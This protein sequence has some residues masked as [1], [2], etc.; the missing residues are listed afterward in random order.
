MIK[1]FQ[2]VIPLMLFGFLFSTPPVH[3]H[4]KVRIT[5]GNNYR[6]L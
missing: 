6:G 5:Y 4:E 2:P 1:R 3:A